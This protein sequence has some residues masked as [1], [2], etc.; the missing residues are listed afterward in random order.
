MK[1][2][3]LLLIGIIFSSLSIHSQEVEVDSIKTEGWKRS[4]ITR[5]LVNQTAFSNWISGGENSIAATLTV[6][7]NI[8]YYKNGWSWDTKMIGSFGINKNSD[9]KYFKKIDDRIEIN[10][11]IGKKFVEK[12]SF[13]SFLNFKTQFAKGFKYSNASDD[14]EIREE[15]TRFLSPAYLQIGVGV[16][17]K[18]NNS[19]WVN[20]APVTGRLILANK[21]FT[22]NLDD[23]QEYF[24]VL[25]GE[26]S[27]FEL[28]A[29]LS[30]YYKFEVIENIQLE[31]RINLYS[32]YLDQPENIDV[33]YTIS[34]FMKVNDYL[35]TN[36]IIQCLYDDNAIKK[37]QLREVFGLAINLNLMELPT[38]K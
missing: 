5:F 6:D 13:S 31:Q 35:S 1:Q 10:S 11:L 12:F 19:L 25:K 16:Y 20:M 22:D 2:T 34:A 32:D 9:S 18:E 38:F 37:V 15:T 4:G 36:L 17:W 26:I 21:K 3:S 23:G 7:Y 14:I 33:D 27:R 8:N 24:G 30:A 28:G 29:S